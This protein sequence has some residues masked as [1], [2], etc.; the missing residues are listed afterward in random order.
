MILRRI[1][2]TLDGQEFD[3]HI[4]LESGKGSQRQRA[5][6]GTVPNMVFFNL[7]KKGKKCASVCGRQR[8]KQGYEYD[9]NVYVNAVS[10]STGKRSWMN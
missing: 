5:S 9:G 2:G 4:Y 6:L 8:G 3:N 1:F 7:T 10:H